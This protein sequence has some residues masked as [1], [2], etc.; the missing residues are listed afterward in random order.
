MNIKKYY[1]FANVTFVVVPWQNMFSKD[2]FKYDLIVCMD[3][4]DKFNLKILCRDDPLH[5][6]FKLLE[7]SRS[8][9]EMSNDDVMFY[10]QVKYGKRR[11][12][13]WLK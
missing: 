3:E 10:M 13:A 9:N 7:F 8:T 4:W 12:K 2:Y 1:L 11:A 5:K 6:I